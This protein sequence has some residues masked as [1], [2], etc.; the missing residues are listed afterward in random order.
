MEVDIL[1]D[2][3]LHVTTITL[4]NTIALNKTI[5]ILFLEVSTLDH[6]QEFAVIFRQNRSISIKESTISYI[7]ITLNNICE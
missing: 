6:Y 1:K 7:L 5:V 4:T 2:G 3:S